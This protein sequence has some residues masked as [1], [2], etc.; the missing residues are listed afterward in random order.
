MTKDEGATEVPKVEVKMECPGAGDGRMMAHKEEWVW[1]LDQN[2]KRV[3]TD[4]VRCVR[5]GR[6]RVNDKRGASDV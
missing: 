3:M 4:K 5:C 1:E 6:I 2:Q